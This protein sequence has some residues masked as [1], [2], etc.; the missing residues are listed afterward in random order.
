MYY[1]FK[2]PCLCCDA[3]CTG[4]SVL[5]K[6]SCKC[7]HGICSGLQDCWNETIGGIY[8][9]PVGGYVILTWLTMMVTSALSGIAW[10]T[11]NCD[12]DESDTN[13]KIALAVA[14]VCGLIHSLCVC[15]IQR[16][17]LKS[18]TKELDKE[19]SD[20]PEAERTY[21]ITNNYRTCV[22]K[23]IWEVIKYD[24]VFL[25]YF[26]FCPA[27]LCLGCYGMFIVPQCTDNDAW[28]AAWAFGGL[29][30]YN[31]FSGLYFF[32]LMCGICCGAGAETVKTQVKNAK[33]GVV[34]PTSTTASS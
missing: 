26:F 33:K 25:F 31:G 28:A 1:L 13:A 11:I 7:C 32:W 2:A 23:A 27:V 3:M 14:I 6:E 4:I 30:F 19:Q 16:A 21:D 10:S 24:F 20:I 22:R 34:K 12:K 29:I 8:H 9:K 17:V 5:C 18:I 15:W